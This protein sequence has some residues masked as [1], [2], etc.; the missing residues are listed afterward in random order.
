MPATTDPNL[1]VKYG[2]AERESGWKPDMDANLLMFGTLIGLAVLDRPAT[3]VPPTPTLG[4]RYIVPTGGANAMKI[5]V[6][7]GTQFI[8]YTPKEGWI[9]YVLDEQV[10]CG[11]NG[12]TWDILNIAPAP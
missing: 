8:Y 10:W 7:D 1:G 12:T 9:C 5:A 11:F 4:D 6:G 2:W 3:W